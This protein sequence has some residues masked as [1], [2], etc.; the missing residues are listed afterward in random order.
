MRAESIF[1]DSLR[2]L[3]NL[4]EK[5]GIA[6]GLEAV[7]A[8]RAANGQAFQAGVLIGAADALREQIGVAALPYIRH[9]WQLFVIDAESSLGAERWQ[10]ARTEG[11]AL[12]LREAVA[13]AV[14]GED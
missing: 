2:S 10:V 4:D 1:A 14:E 3:A 11:M 13:R 9:V 12:V 6:D 7:A 5:S 8:T